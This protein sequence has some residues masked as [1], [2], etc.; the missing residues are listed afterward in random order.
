[1]NRK[2]TEFITIDAGKCKACWDC[3]DECPRA[4]IGKVKFLWHKHIVIKHPDAC[5]GC[6]KCVKAC[7]HGVFS[8]KG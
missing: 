3:V 5:I 8:A 7:R 6:G 1:M 2:K 4:V